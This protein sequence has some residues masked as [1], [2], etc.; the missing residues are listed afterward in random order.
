M[1]LK[2]KQKNL[3]KNTGIIAIGTLLSKFLTF[4][5][6]P[7]Y[8]KYLSADNYGII[9][10]IQNISFLLLPI[11]SL[12]LSSGI[13]RYIIE[14][15]EFEEKKTIVS[16]ALI[17]QFFIIL[18]FV[19]L[20]IITNCFIKIQYF[21]IFILYFITL[22]IVTN[23]QFITRGLGNNKIYS[24]ISFF[25]TFISLILNIVFI[26]LLKWNASSILIA[27]II[28]NLIAIIL[29]LLMTPIIKLI[30]FKKYSR[31]EI[32]VLLKYSLPLIPNEIS[33]WIAN[34]SDRILIS[35]FIDVSANGV[36]AIANKIPGIYTAIF[37]AYNMA[38]VESVSRGIND[39]NS[40]TFIKD[41]Y[42]K[43]FDFLG[44]VCLLIICGTSLFFN[45]IINKNYSDSYFHIL[46]LTIAIYFNSLSS[47]IGSILTGYKDSKTIGFTTI[48]GA[49]IN[50]LINLVFIK[51]IGLYAASISTLI[52]YIII[53]IIR[54]FK[55]RKHIKLNYP[56]KKIIK[57][58]TF[59]I[60]VCW[61]Y[62]IK[63]YIINIIIL[64]LLFIS[65]IIT[66]KN[67]IKILKDK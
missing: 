56:S 29:Y 39:L 37:N 62:F 30:S 54:E 63:N 64:V 1:N 38:W 13:F 42:K 36:Y 46:I 51:I 24:I 8:T 60:I 52:S 14:K 25:T 7:I 17:I 10:L 22:I 27:F 23:F 19:F 31:K 34:A 44:Y 49:I 26:V 28:S 59:L 9:D 48:F 57:L 58:I 65:F 33:W 66:N 40:E 43:S 6:L 55:V 35:S 4:V 18:L 20:T 61:G 53:F 32:K 2:N 12:Q 15:K 47:L 5:L 41:M 50:I 11:V 16:T 3:F 21:E 67:I 45:I